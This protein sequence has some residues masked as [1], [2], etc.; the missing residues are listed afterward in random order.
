[1]VFLEVELSWNVLIAPDNLYA[2]GL[3]LQRSII[4]RILEDI[5]NRKASKEYGYFVAVTTLENIGEGKVRELTGDVLF[6]VVF[7]CVT[8]KPLKGEI[9]LGTVNKVLRHGIVLKSGPLEG[10][11]LSSQVMRD[12]EYIAGENPMFLSEKLS[13]LEKGCMVRF[14]VL[15]FKWMEVDREFQVLA[16]LAG[17]YLGPILED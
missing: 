1:M 3:K 12:Y 2:E 8:F 10:I 11:F 15:G 6:P 7:K 14:K 17:D 16:T 4:L 5:S 13:K 9:L